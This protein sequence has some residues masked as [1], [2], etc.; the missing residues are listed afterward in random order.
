M[1]RN[2]ALSQGLLSSGGG[3][4]L[5]CKCSKRTPPQS[6]EGRLHLNGQ[7][8]AYT[9]THVTSKIPSSKGYGLWNQTDMNA[10]SR[11]GIHLLALDSH[12]APLIFLI[13]SE[14]TILSLFLMI[15]ISKSIP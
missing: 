13:C 8:Q 9:E 6:K 12:L 3:G 14:I 15:K 2:E 4:A 1:P 10:N 11:D 5:F 7:V